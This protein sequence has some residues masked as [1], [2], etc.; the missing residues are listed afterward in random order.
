MCKRR[1]WHNF[2]EGQLWIWTDIESFVLL[3]T[4]FYLAAILIVTGA[5]VICLFVLSV[6]VV[7][8][9]VSCIFSFS[10]INSR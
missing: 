4:N 8:V 1:G 5:I 9:V 6:L 10:F 7:R 3:Y 2:P